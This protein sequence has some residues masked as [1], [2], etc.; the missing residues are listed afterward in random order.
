MQIV[1]KGDNIYISLSS[2]ELAQRVVKF[3]PFF[4]LLSGLP[5]EK[6]E[7][8]KTAKTEIS[9][10][11]DG[12]W[13]E[14]HVGMQGVQNHRTFRFKLGEPYE[15]ASLDG[16]PMKVSSQQTHNVETTSILFQHCVSIGL[17]PYLK[18]WNNNNNKQ[19]ASW[20]KKISDEE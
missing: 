10:R 8:F 1:C 12:D 7:F 14:I 20:K 11:T 15:S 13:W 5:P 9:Y 6:K 16:S 19:D 4:V 17:F 18:A 3:Q 2:A